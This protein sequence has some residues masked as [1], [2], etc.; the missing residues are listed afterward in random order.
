MLFF[1]FFLKS[2]NKKAAA[3]PFVLAAPLDPEKGMDSYCIQNFVESGWKFCFFSQ[4]GKSVH[5]VFNRFALCL[6]VYRAGWGSASL[7]T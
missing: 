5:A 7:I 3:L 6:C 1:F 4:S 2:K